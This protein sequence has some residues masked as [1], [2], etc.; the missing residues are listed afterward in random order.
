MIQRPLLST[1]IGA[2]LASATLAQTDVFVPS[3]AST[4]QPAVATLPGLVSGGRQQILIDASHLNPALLGRTISA[5]SVRRDE[6]HARELRGGTATLTIT[7]GPAASSAAD[8]SREFADN[9]APSPSTAQVVFSGLVTIP[10]S[11]ALQGRASGWGQAEDVVTISFSTGYVYSG[12]GLCIEIEGQQT[13][14]NE[15]KWFVDAAY[16]SLAGTATQFGQGCGSTND[17]QVGLSTL[18]PGSTAAFTA[19]APHPAIGVL[20]IGTA[21]PD[22]PLDLLGVA[23]PGCALRVNPVAQVAGVS[24]ALPPQH[25]LEGIGVF[26]LS[27]PN[28]SYALGANLAA[29]VATLTSHVEVSEGLDFTIASAV[30][31]LGMSTVWAPWDSAVIPTTGTVMPTIA[32]ALRLSTSN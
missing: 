21:I 11:S 20:M 3:A 26:K 32:P 30:P 2:S 15:P 1:L 17:L 29:Q 18:T 16:E 13:V 9:H 14:G 22:V 10:T 23:P 12:G 4:E 24:Q 27:I 8:A 31:S 6:S 7:I 25:V 19:F 28:G 5:L